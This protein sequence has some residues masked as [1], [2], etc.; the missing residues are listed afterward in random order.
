MSI[1]SR[2]LEKEH[3]NK[4]THKS[5]IVSRLGAKVQ[6]EPDYRWWEKKWIQQPLLN[7]KHK[8]EGGKRQTANLQSVNQN[9]RA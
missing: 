6:Q 1:M 7:E 9:Q 8:E 2:E 4:Q 5:L 3:K